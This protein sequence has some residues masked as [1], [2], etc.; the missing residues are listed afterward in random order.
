MKNVSLVLWFCVFLISFLRESKVASQGQGHGVYSVY[1]GAKGSSDDQLQLMSSLTTRRKN[2]VVHSYKNSFS[3][4]A[5]HLSDV[6]AQ[7]IAQQPGVVSVFPDP[8]FQLHKMRSWDF[9]NHQYDLVHNFLYSSGSNS[10]SNGADTIIGIF[11]SG[12]WPESECF[13]DKG[14]GPIPSRWKGTCTRGYDFNSSC[15][16]RS[17][18]VHC[19]WRR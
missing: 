15:C 4:F 18:R 2:A 10:S 19:W 12:I 6:E 8:A 9:L 7:S 3:G 16:N 5:A 17:G 1:M 13:N 11:D 14:I